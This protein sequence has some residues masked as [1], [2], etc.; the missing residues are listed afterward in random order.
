ML[1][2]RILNFLAKARELHSIFLR[3]F[4]KQFNYL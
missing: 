2:E 1:I 3:C 4:L